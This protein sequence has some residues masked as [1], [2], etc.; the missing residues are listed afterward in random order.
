MTLASVGNGGHELAM[1]SVSHTE[2]VDQ[3]IWY[4]LIN[5]TWIIQ[6]KNICNLIQF[7][8]SSAQAL[9]QA[10][11]DLSQKLLKPLEVYF[12]GTKAI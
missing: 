1:S 4:E 12:W 3:F 2:Q 9:H 5:I 7:K 11:T 6:K 10:Q 8:P